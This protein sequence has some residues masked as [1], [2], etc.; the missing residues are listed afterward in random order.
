MNKPSLPP[1]DLPPVEVS[2]FDELLHRHLEQVSSNR[3]YQL[4]DSTQQALLSLCRW[5]IEM[6]GGILTLMLL[7]GDRESYPQI[8]EVIPQLLQHLKLLANNS[9]ICIQRPTTRGILWRFEVEELSNNE[10]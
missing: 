10:T 8:V 4:C 6:N 5:S 1:D 7:C 2:L 3:F 9:K